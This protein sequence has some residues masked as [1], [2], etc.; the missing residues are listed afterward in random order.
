MITATPAAS[1]V[2]TQHAPGNEARL[3]DIRSYYNAVADDYR[4][5]SPGMNMHFG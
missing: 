3:A 2:T 1:R 5:W 4:A